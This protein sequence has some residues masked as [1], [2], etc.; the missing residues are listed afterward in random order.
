MKEI[1][2]V[3][4]NKQ[5]RK[6]FAYD[7]DKDV[8]TQYGFIKAG[9]LKKDK[10]STNTGKELHIFDPSFIDSYRK[11]KRGAQIVSLKDIGFII[12]ETGIDKNS[13]VV[14]AGAG[15][16]ALSLFLAHL[17]KDVTTYEIREDFMKIV[18]GNIDFLKLKNIKI[19]DK[20]IYEGISEKNVDLITLDVPEPWKVLEHASKALKPGGFLISYSP[21]V[22]QVED[23]VNAAIKMDDFVVLK[24]VEIIEREWEVEERRVRPK[25]KGIGHTGFLSVVRR[26]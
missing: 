7:L 16:G 4:I 2:K 12:S 24:T 6:F 17:V 15:S 22:P 20:D 5:G 8:H 13:K 9:D 26:I 25:S 23:F 11:I 1:K 18:K 19:K 3:L 21:S 10:A 14:D